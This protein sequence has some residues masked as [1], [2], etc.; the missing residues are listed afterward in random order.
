MAIENS[1]SSLNLPVGNAPTSGQPAVT[2]N[3]S[4]GAGA[5]RPDQTGAPPQNTETTQ[6]AVA[7][8]EKLRRR[9][10]PANDPLDLEGAFKRLASLLALGEPHLDAPRG[11]Y[12]NI[13]V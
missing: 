6:P 1:R 13:L 7:L 2:P 3:A 10:R 9:V 4:A 8:V 11:Y 5:V 12:L